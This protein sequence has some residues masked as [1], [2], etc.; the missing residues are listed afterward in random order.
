VILHYPT[1]S[2]AVEASRDAAQAVSMAD[3]RILCRVLGKWKV[4]VDARDISIAPALAMD[5]IMYPHILEVLCDLIRP[6][7]TCVDV[8]SCYGYTAL[9]QAELVGKQGRVFCFEPNARVFLMLK[10][11]LQLNDYCPRAMPCPDA[12]GA[13]Q[14]NGSLAI[15]KRIFNG[16]TLSEKAQA[17]FG[18]SATELVQVTSLDD[19]LGLRGVHPDF[20]CISTVGYEPQV[21]R[22]MKGLLA[23]KRKITI[24]MEFTPRWYA[25]PVAFAREIIDQGFVC[26]R[27]YP[28]GYQ[29]PL[30][31]PEKFTK[32][33]RSDLVL[34]R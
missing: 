5:G 2:Q 29:E 31:E 7:M 32:G 10:H 9:L 12:V 1:Q 22:G 15:H 13:M 34:T 4:L 27:L 8:G 21:W 25:D 17:S 26:C 33:F 18:E 24:L 16:A 3:N 28:D 11:N 23:A 14:G 6:G 30:T 19:R 20:F